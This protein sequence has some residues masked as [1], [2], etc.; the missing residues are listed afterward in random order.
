MSKTLFLAAILV[1]TVAA[2]AKKQETAYVEQPVSQEPVF[3][4]KYQ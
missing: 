1:A 3:T 4:G 2:C